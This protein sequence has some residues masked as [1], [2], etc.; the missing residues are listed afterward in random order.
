MTI[1]SQ[2]VVMNPPAPRSRAPPARLCS[3]YL[4]TPVQQQRYGGKV[5]FIS[6]PVPPVRAKKQKLEGLKMEEVPDCTVLCNSKKLAAVVNSSTCK[7]RSCKG[8]TRIMSA[9]FSGL[10]GVCVFDTKCSQCGHKVL[11]ESG[12]CYNASRTDHRTRRFAEATLLHIG[13]IF[14]G[15][16]TTAYKET[17]AAAGL[18]SWAPQSLTVYFPRYYRA[19]EQLLNES[20]A[21]VHDIIEEREENSWDNFTGPVEQQRLHCPFMPVAHT[22]V[23]DC[24]EQLAKWLAYLEKNLLADVDQFCTP[25]GA[26]RTNQVETVWK[27]FLK[28]RNKDSNIAGDMYVF[29][30]NLAACYFNQQYIS[31]HRPGYCVRSR[32]AEILGVPVPEATRLAWAKSNQQRERDSVR[33]HKDEHK[34]KV[35]TQ[36]MNKRKEKIADAENAKKHK[37]ELYES[38]GYRFSDK[39]ELEEQ[40]D[41]AAE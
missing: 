15:G 34:V 29:S 20:L 5:K 4:Q 12:T 1:T 11:F 26:V 3:E 21:L 8:L 38:G 14:G 32:F 25:V 37:G 23:F 27:A 33:R 16:G 40:A 2:L 28:F 7:R 36:K 19:A 22:H 9:Q 13:V 35:N 10:G 39:V 30:T 18:S 41:K 31:Q 17:T 6:P 24:P